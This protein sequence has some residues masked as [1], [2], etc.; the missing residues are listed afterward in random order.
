MDNPVKKIKKS[1]KRHTIVEDAFSAVLIALGY[2]N[3][4][5]VNINSMY[6][7]YRKL[8]RKYKHLIAKKEFDKSDCEDKSNTIWVCWLQGIDNAPELVKICYESIKYHCKDWNIVL[9]DKTNLFDYI[10][11]PDYIVKKWEKGII[12]NTHFSD[13]VRMDLLIRYGG[14]WI[15]STT[16]LTAPIPEYVTS[17]DFFVFRNGWF[18]NEMIN[19]GSWFIYSK[20]DNILLLETQNLLFEYWKKKNYLNQYFLMHIFFRMVSDH[21]FD[22]W[23]AVKYYNHINQHV[24][25]MELDKKYDEKRMK[26]ISKLTP[27]HKLSNKIDI[28]SFDKESYYYKLPQIYKQDF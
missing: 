14:L 27:I 5:M 1:I 18:N 25:A 12:S 28:A 19:F 22:E 26:Q 16:Y 24:L 17:D 11:L 9:I 7:T 6:K 10:Q 20:K 23:Q 3:K 4:Y 21:Y 2:G 8:N 15:D 13:M